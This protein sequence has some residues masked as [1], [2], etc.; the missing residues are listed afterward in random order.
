VSLSGSVTLAASEI[1]HLGRLNLTMNYANLWNHNGYGVPGNLYS[2]SSGWF[3]GVQR[4]VQ[5]VAGGFSGG[6]A[7]LTLQS[8]TW[9]GGPA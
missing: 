5:R 3:N 9:S 6:S 4:H 1:D 7:G 8:R 2:N